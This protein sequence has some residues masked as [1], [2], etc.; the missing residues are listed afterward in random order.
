M[1]KE[2][3]KQESNKLSTHDQTQTTRSLTL[4][5]SSQMLRKLHAPFSSCQTVEVFR[6]NNVTKN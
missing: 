2:A 3:I 6:V 1:S 4:T 5:P